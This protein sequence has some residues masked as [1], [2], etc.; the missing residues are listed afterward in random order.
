MFLEPKTYL[1]VAL[2]L[3]VNAG[4][5]VTNTFGPLIINGL[6]FDKYT[7]SLLNIPFGFV[8]W[9]IILLAS[10]LV[11]RFRIKSAIVLIFI[12]PVI[13]G[14][15]VLYAVPRTPDHTGPLLVGYYLLAFLFG[16]IPVVVAWVVANTAGM[17]KRSVIMCK[18]KIIHLLHFAQLLEICTRLLTTLLQL[19]T[20]EPPPLET[21][22]VPSFSTPRTRPTTSQVCASCS[23][24]SSRRPCAP[25][26]RPSTSPS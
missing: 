10:W 5:S 4:A 20:T 1:W 19:Y 3:F 13:A 24:S 22:S 14:L 8:Q 12:L 18:S 25:S 21:S 11:Q 26:C 6:N 7:T 9:V 23:A 15:A 17:T 2:S 16:T